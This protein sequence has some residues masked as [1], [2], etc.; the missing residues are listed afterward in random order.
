[1][2]FEKT[3]FQETELG[4]LL[5]KLLFQL[6]LMSDS[7]NDMVRL[8][9]ESHGAQVCRSRFSTLFPRRL[10]RCNCRAS[11]NG[12]NIVRSL[13]VYRTGGANKSLSRIAPVLW[14]RRRQ[15]GFVHAV[16]FRQRVSSP[17][18]WSLAPQQW[19]DDKFLEFRGQ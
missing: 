19:W 16:A 8:V 2:L 7:L 11:Y 15:H 10:C 18:R 3:L 1:M 12:V 13:L 17:F 9:N 14:R 4:K 5:S 6:M